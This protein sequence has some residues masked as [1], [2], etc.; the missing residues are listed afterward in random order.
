[1]I[2]N[3]GGALGST[4]LSLYR[5]AVEREKPDAQRESGFQQRD[6][7]GFEGGLK[8]MDRRYVAAMD[9]QLQRYWL[10]QYIPCR[11]TSVFPP[12]TSGSVATMP[13]RWM[14]RSSASTPASWAMW[15]SA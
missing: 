15:T 4:A 7:P 12:S 14:P 3:V 10:M 1:M 9:R 13:R 5:L 11:P 2:G 8:Q 6:L